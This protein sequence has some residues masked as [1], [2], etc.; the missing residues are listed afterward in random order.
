MVQ[1]FH[2]IAEFRGAA[3]VLALSTLTM[4]AFVAYLLVV[5]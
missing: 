5:A 2:N 1:F 4:Y 3:W